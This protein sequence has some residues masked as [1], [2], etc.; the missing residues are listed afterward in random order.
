[1]NGNQLALDDALFEHDAL[2]WKTLSSR[3]LTY[4]APGYTSLDIR[5]PDTDWLGIWTK[6]C[7]SF[8]CIEPWVGSAD[9]H[10]YQGDFTDKSGVMRLTPEQERHFRMDVTLVT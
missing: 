2:I 1:V 10:G 7:A 8:V 5:F 4:G 3:R 9:D 6:P